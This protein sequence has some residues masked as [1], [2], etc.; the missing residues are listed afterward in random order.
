MFSFRLHL[1]FLFFKTKHHVYEKQE[2]LKS[3]EMKEIGPRFELQLYQI[4]A[5]Y[6]I[7]VTWILLQI[8]WI[9]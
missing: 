9:L 1:N 6:A 8:L 7:Q 4:I 5:P 2:G 3:I